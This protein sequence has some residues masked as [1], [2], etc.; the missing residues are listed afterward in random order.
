[1]R[2]LDAGEGARSRKLQANRDRAGRSVDLGSWAQPNRIIARLEPPGKAAFGAG[3]TLR[4]AAC[5]LPN[6]D[7]P[8]DSQSKHELWIV[9][10]ISLAPIPLLTITALIVAL[11]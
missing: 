6:G 7:R 10:A 5:Y 1:V 2:A 3:G 8:M 9:T 4:P 11:Q